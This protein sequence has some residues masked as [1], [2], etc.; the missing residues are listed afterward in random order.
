MDFFL[1]PEGLEF[2]FPRFSPIVEGFSYKCPLTGQCSKQLFGAH[3]IHVVV[4]DPEAYTYDDEVI[5]KAEAM[6]IL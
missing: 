6:R 1:S 2:T 3:F 4:V 5:K